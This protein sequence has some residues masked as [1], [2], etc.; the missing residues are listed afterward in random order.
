MALSGGLLAAR[1]FLGPGG[2]VHSP[3]NVEGIFALLFLAQ[4]MW[5][6]PSACPAAPSPNAPNPILLPI[7]VTAA[8]AAFLAFPFLADDYSHIWNAHHADARALL[9]HFTQPEKDQFFR[10]LGYLSY[11]LDA[12][13]AGYNPALWRASNLAIHVANTLLVYWLCREIGFART[14]AFVG[15]LIFGLHGSRPEAVTW[16]AARFDLLA[17]L[18]SLGC[19]LAVLRGRNIALAGALLVAALASKESAY[20]TPVLAVV[21]LYYRREAVRKTWPLFAIAAAMFSYRMWLLKGI[22][23]YHDTVNGSATVF[24]FRLTSTLKALFPRFW[25]TLIFPINWTGGLGLLLAIALLAAIAALCVLAWRGAD[26][27]QLLLGI[28]IAT[29][30]SLPVHQFLSI[31]PD[32]E[33]SRVLYMASI[34]LAILFAALF[35]RFDRTAAVCAVALIG[36]QAI[37]LEHNLQQWKR[38]GYLAE[39]TCSAAA[40]ALAADPRPLTVR[41]LPNVLDGVYFLHTGYPECVLIQQPEA[42]GRFAAGGQTLAWDPANNQLILARP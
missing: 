39:R 17:V 23:G 9:A 8:F 42:A 1:G 27:R 15:A 30:C 11:T 21:L 14:A 32:L 3:M 28:G 35:E 4:A 22:G 37:A 26:R 7:L 20:V 31:G 41:G 12:L 38:V 19:I 13:W 6:R 34:G 25:A 24:N 29:V 18:F 16:V 2:I 36:Y 40:R 10:P 33:K 5:D